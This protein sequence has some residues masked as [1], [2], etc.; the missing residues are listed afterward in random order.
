MMLEQY[1]EKPLGNYINIYK[2]KPK[3]SYGVVTS[4]LCYLLEDKFIDGVISTQRVGA[5]GKVII[6]KTKEEII[7]SAGN[8]WHVVPYTLEMK[9]AIESEGLYNL[10]IVG[11]PCQMSFLR[12][13][14]M[15]PLIEANFGER[16][17]CLISLFCYGTFDQESVFNFLR[18][19]YDVEPSSIDE[20]KTTDKSLNVIIEDK[21]IEIPLENVSQY[22]HSGCL[23][24]PDYT[25]SPSDLSAGFVNKEKVII[26][27][28][29]EMDYRIREAD[30]L[31][32]FEIKEAD[33]ETIKKIE[34]RALRKVN[35]ALEL[36]KEQI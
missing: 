19:K 23:L 17:S 25:G 28:T 6:A 31:G 24:C 35:R 36:Y 11:L 18:E 15:F 1:K 14:K 30:K 9:D 34:E 10:A 21:Q 4:F 2:A 29:K 13:I 5:G 32:Y 8:V 20:I 27:R 22:L 33:K 12:Q 16:I 7:A 26:T 3:K